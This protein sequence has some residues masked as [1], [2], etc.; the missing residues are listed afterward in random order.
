M[1]FRSFTSLMLIP[2]N[3]ILLQYWYSSKSECHIKNSTKETKILQL[4][5]CEKIS[6]S[7]ALIG[8]K[9]S[10]IFWKDCIRH[11]FNIF[12]TYW[13]FFFRIST[14][15]Y[16]CKWSCKLQ[17]RFLGKKKKKKKNECRSNYGIV[18]DVN[19]PRE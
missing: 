10:D 16:T 4:L 8:L 1:S 13:G 11:I 2:L 15:S 14:A 12:N 5:L 18:L 17:A 6:K 9:Q 19:Q 7:F 3:I